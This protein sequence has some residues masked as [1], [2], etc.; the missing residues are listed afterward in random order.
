[1]LL[2]KQYD[3]LGD[4]R[5]FVNNVFDMSCQSCSGLKKLTRDLQRLFLEICRHIYEI[6]DVLWSA[7]F[8]RASYELKNILMCLMT[9]AH[10]CHTLIQLELMKQDLSLIVT[11]SACL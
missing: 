4:L 6:E 2:L 8:L 5:A 10:V 9:P 3:A 1:M 7:S 11:S